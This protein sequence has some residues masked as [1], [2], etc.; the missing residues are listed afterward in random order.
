MKIVNSL[1]K[2][3]LMCLMCLST[4]Q[5]QTRQDLKLKCLSSNENK[6]LNELYSVFERKLI[7]RYGNLKRHELIFN[8]VNDNAL[9]SFDK[10]DTSFFKSFQVDTTSIEFHRMF[11][12]NSQLPQ[13]IFDDD[14][15][16]LGHGAVISEHGEIIEFGDIK[17]REPKDYYVISPNS[18]YTQ[19]FLQQKSKN[20]KINNVLSVSFTIDIS[21]SIIVPVFSSSFKQNE[22]KDQLLQIY[23]MFHLFL[24]PNL[25][26]QSM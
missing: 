14:I 17:H 9:F 18:I 3:F 6:Y 8:Y 5:C 15:V 23:V 20:Y 25:H 26:L 7:D 19:C 2:Y 21:P 10:I 11:I 24:L 12:R 1:M 16:V 22:Y 4:A 13:E